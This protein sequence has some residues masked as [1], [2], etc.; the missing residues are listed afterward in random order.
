MTAPVI[1]RAGDGSVMKGDLRGPGDGASR[2]TASWFYLLGFFAIFSTTIAKNP[3]LPLFASAL[4][5]GDAVVGLIAFFSPFAG[6]LFSFPVG[7]VSDRLGRRRLLVA[8]GVVFA[9]AP[10]LYLFVT[11]PAWLIPVRFFHG[12]ATAILGPVVSAAIAERFPGRRGEALG[13]YSSATL[14]GRTAAPLAGGA[15]LFSFAAC[16]GLVPYRAVYAVAAGAGIIVLAMTLRYREDGEGRLGTVPL[17]VFR[18]GLRAFVA[19]RR[20]LGTAGAEMATYF[21]FGAFETFLPLL[22]A[23]RGVG[24]EGAGVVF[25]VQVLVIAA[26]K[27]LFGRLAD[28]GD[29]R[30]LIATGLLVTA[31]MSVLVPFAPSFPAL[32]AVSGLFGL[33]Q[34]ATTVASSAYVADVAGPGRTGAAMGALAAIM[35]VGHSTGPLVTGIV[36]GAAGYAWGFGVGALLT[37]AIAAAFV[38]LAGRPRRGSGD[39]KGL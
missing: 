17:P 23:S 39:T 1:S 36:I 28:R 29:P 25:A 19:D 38:L 16:P 31:G 15:I 2:K 32:L 26:G 14:L 6:I 5:A 22:L 11:D 13:Q 27:P 8:A 4:G 3:V 12:T 37:G 24:A 10:L 34:A 7:V 30:A 9:A 20:L 33:G 18:E 35:D 21:A